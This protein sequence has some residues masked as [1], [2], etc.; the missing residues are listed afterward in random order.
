MTGVENLTYLAG[1]RKAAGQ[2]EI[3]DAI[4][5]VGL[6]PEDI[7]VTA[8]EKMRKSLPMAQEI[9]KVEVLDRVE[10]LAGTSRQ[11]VRVE[12]VYQ[13]D[14]TEKGEEIYLTF[15]RWSLS[16]YGEPASLERGFVNILEEGEEYLAFVGEQAEAMGEELPVYQL[17]GES[18]IAPVFSCR[19]HTNTI[20]EM[21]KKS[22]Y[23]PYR[24]VCENEFFASSLKALE[25]LEVL[26][27]EMM[28]KYLKGES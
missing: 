23:V 15:G 7:A 25:A 6:D 27:A 4:R 2:A 28:Q 22:T 3:L 11:R 21:G 19:D 26:K 24:S 16:L 5:R 20:S 17:Y 13:G 1:F 10:H 14:C 12:A 18:V 8:C 9:L